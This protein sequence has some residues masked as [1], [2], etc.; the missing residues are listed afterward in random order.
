MTPE[1]QYWEPYGE[2][3]ASNKAALTNSKGEM[4]PFEYELKEFVT[5]ED[6]PNMD[7]VLVVNDAVNRQDLDAVIAP[8]AVQD[9]DFDKASICIN[10]RMSEVAAAAVKP[11][12]LD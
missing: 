5:E 4:R 11:F 10:L 6:Y 8:F 2:S 1:G 7:S 9:V 12:I 3:Y